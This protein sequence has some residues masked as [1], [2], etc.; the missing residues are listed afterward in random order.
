MSAFN[1]NYLEKVLRDVES[2][3]IGRYDY[4]KLVALWSVIEV[5]IEA[6]FEPR[7]STK[8]QLERALTPTNPLVHFYNTAI[9]KPNYEGLVTMAKQLGITKFGKG[10][11]LQN[12]GVDMILLVYE[13]RNRIVH[14]EWQL[15]SQTSNPFAGAISEAYKM[16]IHWIK[17]AFYDPNLRP[18][19]RSARYH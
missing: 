7:T 13:I 5:W 14:G 3:P 17:L 16:L 19:Q 1:S 10:E 2:I 6:D 18:F 12:N 9:H 8:D 4:L 11:E 15:D